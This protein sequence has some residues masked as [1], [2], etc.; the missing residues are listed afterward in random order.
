MNIVLYRFTI[1]ALS[2]VCLLGLTVHAGARIL[3]DRGIVS[4]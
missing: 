4:F 1:F 3:H 2:T